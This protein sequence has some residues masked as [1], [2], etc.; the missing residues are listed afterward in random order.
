M[1]EIRAASL[2]EV[3]A[4]GTRLVEIDGTRVVLTRI[5]DSVHACGD[6]CAH[7]GGS[8]SEGRL[9]GVK[10]AC[11]LHGWIYDVRTGQCLF[12]GRGASVPSY[13]VRIEDDDIFVELP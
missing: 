1:S 10:L 7:R 9:S 11:P 4:S 13:R 8:L 12:P 5:G 6:T 3:P 2:T